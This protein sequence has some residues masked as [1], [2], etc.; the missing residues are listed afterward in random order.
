MKATITRWIMTTPDVV[1]NN[2]GW[3]YKK[4]TQTFKTEAEAEK[5]MVKYYKAN[6]LYV[7]NA[8]AEMWQIKKSV[9]TVE[10]DD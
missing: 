2:Y 10:V 9:R 6:K 8:P 1:F 5:A 3:D 7:E 4:T